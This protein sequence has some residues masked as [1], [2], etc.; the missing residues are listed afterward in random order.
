MTARLLAHEFAPKGYEALFGLYKY[1]R[2]TGLDHQLLD[3]VDLRA[4]QLNGCAYCTDMHWKDLRAAGVSEEK[5]SLLSVW[6]E[7]PGFTDRER[8][9]LEWCEAVTLVADSH[10]PDEVYRIAREQFSEAELVNLTLAISTINVWNRMAIA[11]RKP[12]GTYK[13][14]SIPK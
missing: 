2:Q 9:A 14:G 3:L 12:A 10:V 13:P 6:R 11:F 7:A 4:S 8:A 1:T 5:L